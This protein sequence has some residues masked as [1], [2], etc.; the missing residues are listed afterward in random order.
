MEMSRLTREGMAEP[1]SRDQII[2]HERGQGNIHFPC[3][4]DHKQDW[5][6]FPLDPYSAICDDHTYI[7]T[8]ILQD[9]RMF[10]FTTTLLTDFLDVE[11]KV[12]ATTY[13]RLRTLHTTAVSC[14]VH[15]RGMV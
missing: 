13:S 2:R 15:H 3:S 8:Y 6:P 12:T 14:V 5:Q 1:V 9:G 7:H 10:V 4:A 11:K